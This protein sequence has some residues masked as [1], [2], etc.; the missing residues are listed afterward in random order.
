MYS[1]YLLYCNWVMCQQEDSDVGA[2]GGNASVVTLGLGLLATALAAAY[3][4][5]LAKVTNDLILSN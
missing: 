4:T 2:L 1:F 5:Q 3:V